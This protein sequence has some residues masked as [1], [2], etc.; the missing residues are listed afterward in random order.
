LKKIDIKEKI[1]KQFVVRDK[2]AE[3][4]KIV[5]HNKEIVKLLRNKTTQISDKPMNER[6]N[7]RIYGT[8]NPNKANNTNQINL[9]PL[10]HY[11]DINANNTK[12]NIV[13]YENNY[14]TNKNIRQSIIISYK[15]ND[16]YRK[17]NLKKLLNYLSQ[18]LDDST[19][20]ILVE[21]DENSKLNW[22]S[23]IEKHN[24][25]NHIFLKN[26]GIFNKGWGYNVGVKEARGNCLIF[27]DS[28]IFIKLDSYSTSLELLN[29][30]DVINPYKSISS[31]NKKNSDLFI[32]NEYKYVFI[33]ND[34]ID[35]MPPISGGIFMI[36]KKNF[37]NLKGFDENCFGWGYE[38]SIFDTKIRKMELSIYL[39]DDTAVHLYH[40]NITEHSNDIYYSFQIRNK[41][42]YN[43]YLN[44][45]KEELE[46]KIKNINF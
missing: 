17:I 32:P 45:S 30:F 5:K 11:D 34:N 22:L 19:E 3:Y 42:I 36:K 12:K 37:L 1:K 7:L 26:M 25:I 24:E 18:A 35:E 16:E 41:D 43:K 2:Q 6:D 31:L 8:S 38:D 29:K 13:V 21:Q 33:K 9:K 4:N 40:K 15:E 14:I 10:N 20:I 23:E 39:C 44:M 27:H 28:D 46:N